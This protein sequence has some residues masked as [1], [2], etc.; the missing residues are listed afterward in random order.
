MIIARQPKNAI[1]WLFL[2]AT[3]PLSDLTGLYAI[4]GTYLT[5]SP[6]PATAVV[7]HLGETLS[8]LSL[9][10]LPYLM[11]LFPDGHFLSPRWRMLGVAMLSLVAF[12]AL[13]FFGPGS[14]DPN[15]PS[16]LDVPGP[17]FVGQ[18]LQGIGALGFVASLIL[19]AISVILRYRRS[20]G[21]QRLQMK[22]MVFACALVLASVPTLA[23]GGWFVF[24]LA[25]NLLPV[26]AGIAIMRYRL[27]EIDVIIRRTL[28]YAA[29][30]VI[31]V[32]AYVI[33]VA[34]LES[35]LAPFTS[36]NSVAVAITTLA[37]VAMFHPA[38]RRMQSA[39]DRRFYRARYDAEHTLDAFA[40]RL[41][42]EVDLDAVEIEL[43]AAVDRSLQPAHASVWL[44]EPA[45]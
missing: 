27:Y 43:L 18:L 1:G 34:A 44:R 37:V 16:P 3:L 25:T 26:A 10:T 41:R 20:R 9:L 29:V 6:L 7:Y 12:A 24:I 13:V 23:L 36:G 17:A 4:Y 21:V 11:L 40:S 28:I 22:W 42:G 33:G 8:T 2:G 31:L 45:R 32:V 5:P 38:R 19:G 39:V 35:L 15:L 30:S 14:T